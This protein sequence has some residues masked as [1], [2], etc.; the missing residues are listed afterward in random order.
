MV[1]NTPGTRAALRDERSQTRER[2]YSVDDEG[3]RAGVYG[4]G[5]PVFDATGTAVA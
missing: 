4:I 2:S 1:G 3:I 5:A